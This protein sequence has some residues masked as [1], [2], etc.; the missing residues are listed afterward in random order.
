MPVLL[1]LSRRVKSPSEFLGYIP[2]WEGTIPATFVRF[3]SHTLHW[4][5]EHNPD[6]HRMCSKNLQIHFP[7]SFLGAYTKIRQDWNMCI[8]YKLVCYTVELTMETGSERAAVPWYYWI[9]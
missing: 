2:S 8:N 9:K 6:F 7:D 3:C 5:P 4:I 1:S